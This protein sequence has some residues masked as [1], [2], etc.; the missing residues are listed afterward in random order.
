M[1]PAGRL[2]PFIDSARWTV[3]AGNVEEHVVA[4][5]AVYYFIFVFRG[6]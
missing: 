6:N 4:V 5:D 2:R 3:A 1:T